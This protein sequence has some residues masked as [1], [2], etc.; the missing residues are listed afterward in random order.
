ML[1]FMMVLPLGPDFAT[2]LGIPTSH[3]G[4]VGGAYTAAG[5]IAG[6]IGAVLLD[7][8]DRRQALAVAIG[9]LVI[10]TALGGFAVDLPTMLGARILA[11]FFGGPAT[12]I[13]LAIIADSVPPQRRGRAMGMVSASFAVASTIGIPLALELATLGGWRMPFFAV[14]TFGA[15]VA[16]LVVWAMPPQRAHL[17]TGDAASRAV[18]LADFGRLLSKPMAR[19][20]MLL[21]GLAMITGFMLIPNFSAWIQFNRGFPREQIGVLYMLGGVVGFFVTRYAGIG[22]DRFG[23]TAIALTAAIVNIFAIWAVFLATNLPVSLYVLFPLFM[24]AN[25]SRFVVVSTVTSKVPDAPERAR[26]MSMTS[27]VQA[28][29][30]SCAA[31]VASAVLIELPGGALGGMPPIATA[32]IALILVVPPL[33]WAVERFVEK[34]AASLRVQTIVETAP[35]R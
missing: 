18:S 14:A 23:G 6:L 16:M 30:S 32:A 11:G 17:Q 2:A 34:R 13:A 3:L 25:A 10:A 31:F 29:S 28:L 7:R 1:D 22:V 8:F 27:S 19:I 21:V 26:F 20:A 12:A 5:F 4:Y 24:G 9:G 35:T 15:V 33:I